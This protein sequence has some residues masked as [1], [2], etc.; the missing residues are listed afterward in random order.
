[1]QE[2][3]SASDDLASEDVGRGARRQVRRHHEREKRTDLDEGSNNSQAC[4]SEVLER[5][6]L[7]GGVE[8]RVQKEGDVGCKGR[9]GQ[10][11]AGDTDSMS[12]TRSQG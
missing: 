8:E 7:A 5:S 1:M 6:C 2:V 11:R 9:A 12:L 10:G 4:Q 3:G